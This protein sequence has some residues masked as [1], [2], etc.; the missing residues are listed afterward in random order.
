MDLSRLTAPRQFCAIAEVAAA[1]APALWFR[2]EQASAD[3]LDVARRLRRRPR[4]ERGEP[5]RCRR[6]A[7]A[8]LGVP[9]DGVPRTAWPATAGRPTR[10]RAVVEESLANIGATVMG[11]NMFGGGAGPWG[12][13]PWNGWWGDN[14]PFHHP[15]FVL[16]HHAR[17]PLVCE[18]GTTFTFVTDGI[19]AALDR[20]RSAAAG[21]D[22][23]ARRRR[24]GC[25]P[26]PR[27]RPGRPDGDHPRADL[28]R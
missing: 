18:G 13:E 22:V 7:P 27:G 6:Y 26:V 12:D 5:A 14:P 28:P 23:A 19:V 8:R 1:L 20:A 4:A 25:P 2:R 16:T 10:A 15:V 21:K 17:E 3:H 24:R 11:R 9:A